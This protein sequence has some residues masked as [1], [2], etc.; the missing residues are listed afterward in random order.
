[1]YVTQNRIFIGG[2]GSPFWYK[3]N[4][5]IYDGDPKPG[6]LAII[7]LAENVNGN[8]VDFSK[9]TCHAHPRKVTY[10]VE[11]SVLRLMEHSGTFEVTQLGDRTYRCTSLN[12]QIL[13]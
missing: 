13:F 8:P 10:Q 3:R 6:A 12:K 11:S 7:A 9:I 5:T 2:L 4:Q 1:M